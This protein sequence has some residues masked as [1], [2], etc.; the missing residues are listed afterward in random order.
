[1]PIPRP[2]HAL[3]CFGCSPG[4]HIAAPMLRHSS[5]NAA[6]PHAGFAV[7]DARGGRQHSPKRNTDQSHPWLQS[8]R[9]SRGA[10]RRTA[11]FQWLIPVENGA[12]ILVPMGNAYMSQPCRE[13]QHAERPCY[14]DPLSHSQATS[15][16]PMYVVSISPSR[17]PPWDPTDSQSQS[18]C[19]RCQVQSDRDLTHSTNCPKRVCACTLWRCID[20]ATVC[21]R[22]LTKRETDHKSNTY[23]PRWAFRSIYERTANSLHR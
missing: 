19:S 4:S 3:L 5:R 17:H 22:G 6:S 21:H 2:R 20:C 23:Q 9:V 1:M 11:H 8:A 15:S 14:A 16:E 10:T 13:G 7:R 18:G 12:G